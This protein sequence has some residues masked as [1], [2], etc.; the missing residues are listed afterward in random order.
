MEAVYP[1]PPS[2]RPQTGLV[3]PELDLP[4]GFQLPQ[5]QPIQRPSVQVTLPSSRPYVS[6]SV[7]TSYTLTYR[8]PY[9]F[10]QKSPQSFALP[11]TVCPSPP[12]VPN[13]SVPRKEGTSY[14][15]ISPKSS[16]RRYRTRSHVDSQIVDLLAERYPDIFEELVEEIKERQGFEEEVYSD[17]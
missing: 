14:R 10:E 11:Q 9:P 5:L 17:F 3:L 2:S 7:P 12:F 15:S 4:S 8:Q 1:S 16:Q 6:S 13:I